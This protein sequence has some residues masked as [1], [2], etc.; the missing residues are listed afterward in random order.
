VQQTVQTRVHA[1]SP[2]AVYGEWQPIMLWIAPPNNVTPP[3]NFQLT[4]WI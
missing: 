1:N 2:V 3:V 4:V